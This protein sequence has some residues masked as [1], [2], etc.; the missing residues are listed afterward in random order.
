MT[1]QRLSICG[2][3]H[4]LLIL[5]VV[6][7]GSACSPQ[8]AQEILATETPVALSFDTA[9]VTATDTATEVTES[10]AVIAA[11]DTNT[12][13]PL[14]TATLTRTL[15]PTATQI[16]S[17]VPTATSTVQ[18]VAAGIIPTPTKNSALTPT[19]PVTETWYVTA[20]IGANVRSCPSTQC[21]ALGWLAYRSAFEYIETVENRDD[22]TPTN[23][24]TYSGSWD[25][26]LLPATFNFRDPNIN[27]NDI[28]Y[29]DTVAYIASTLTNENQPPPPTPIP[30]STA[31]PTSVPVLLPRQTSTPVEVANNPSNNN[32]P[33]RNTQV[34]TNTP[35]STPIPNSTDTPTP[36]PTEVLPGAPVLALIPASTYMGSTQDITLSNINEGV[37]VTFATYLGTP[38]DTLIETFTATADENNEIVLQDTNTFNATFAKGY[39]YG[40]TYT[41]RATVPIT[42][43]DTI[44]DQSFIIPLPSFS[45]SPSNAF[46]DTL[47]TITLGNLEENP[48][49]LDVQLVQ[50]D[51]NNSSIIEATI[52]TFTI[53]IASDGTG[54][55]T[56]TSNDYAMN[57]TDCYRVQFT[58][59]GTVNTLRQGVIIN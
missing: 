37:V 9:T 3:S 28:D 54:R 29:P 41:L 57:T 49:G 40:Q 21:E 43:P 1:I 52:D 36:T 5:I 15:T 26:I 25:K 30:T 4:F 12:P 35:G 6:I 51:C 55:D 42:S 58:I 10:E 19:L 34:P 8:A 13:K 11:S 31:T 16:S 46:M 50:Y 27:R 56:F 33:S 48:I 22:R 18:R 45:V 53:V 39:R 32:R 20:R 14:A 17:P 2:V 47:R 24:A 59:P 44:L 38:P 7:I 23:N